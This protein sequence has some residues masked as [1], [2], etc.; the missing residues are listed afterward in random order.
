M[1]LAIDE[2]DDP[3]QRHVDARGE[4]GRCDKKQDRLLNEWAERPIGRLGA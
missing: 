3:A 1:V 4:K 2:Q